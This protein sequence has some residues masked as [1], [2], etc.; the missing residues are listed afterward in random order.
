M[1]VLH[2]AGLNHLWKA[3]KIIKVLRSW[4]PS[5]PSIPDSKAENLK[6]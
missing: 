6:S 2:K 3:L 1:L 4:D 5:D